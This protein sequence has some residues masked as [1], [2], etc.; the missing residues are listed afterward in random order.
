[1][2]TFGYSPDRAERAKVQLDRDLQQVEYY[3][4]NRIGRT[5]PQAGAITSRLDEALDDVREVVGDLC[6]LIDER[7]EVAA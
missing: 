3:L 1:M 6:D 2:T 4:T 7:T 5:I